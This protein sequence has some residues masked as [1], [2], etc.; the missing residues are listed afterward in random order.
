VTDSLLRRS[1]V[2]DTKEPNSISLLCI[3]IDEKAIAEQL[4]NAYNEQGPNPWKT[5]DGR[6]VPRW[7]DLTDQVREKWKAAAL[8][9]IE[10][11][12]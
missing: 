7:P 8:K 1:I 4:F 5:F 9:A 12:A 2:P 6:D 10:V 3:E 11:L